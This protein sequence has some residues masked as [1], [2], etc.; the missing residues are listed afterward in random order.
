[1]LAPTAIGGQDAQAVAGRGHANGPV[2]DERPICDRGGRTNTDLERR[3]V[4]HAGVGAA[5]EVQEDPDVGRLLQV[6]LLD[7]DVAVPGSRL[8]VDAVEAVARRPRPHGG[9]Q[10]SR[11]ERP[12]GSG[13]A[14]LQPGRRQLPEW[15]PLDAR[16]DDQRDPLPDRRRRLEEPE[17][18]AGPDLERLDPEVAAARQRCADQPRP[19]ASWGERQRPTGQPARQAG[20]VVDLEPELRPAARVPQRVRDAQL[21]PDLAVELA[22]GVPRLE[23]RQAEAR[24]DVTAADD[25]DGEVDEVEEERDRGRE[26]GDDQHRGDD[27]Q[28]QAADHVNPAIA[29]SLA[30]ARSSGRRVADGRP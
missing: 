10:W 7:L 1:M 28:L 24:E 26:C 22:H 6:E 16:I 4:P 12:L 20:R 17:G 8:P 21:V 15:Q 18:I 30:V 23:V 27:E 29:R 3:L 14:A 19:L 2:L 13:V 11:L 5:V 25:Q 9:R